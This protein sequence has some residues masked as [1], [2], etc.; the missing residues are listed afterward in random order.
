V[1]VST[2]IGGGI[3]VDGRLVH[4]RRGMAGHVGHFRMAA[5]GPRCSCG[6]TACFVSLRA[7]EGAPIQQTVARCRAVPSAQQVELC[8]LPRTEAAVNRK[9]RSR[10]EPWPCRQSV[11]RGGRPCCVQ[12]P[13]IRQHRQRSSRATPSPRQA[14]REAQPPQGCDAPVRPRRR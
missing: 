1:T 9:Q 10:P 14:A 7:N 3:V 4:G 11:G 2:G 6:A 5:D 12:K 13:V 8:C